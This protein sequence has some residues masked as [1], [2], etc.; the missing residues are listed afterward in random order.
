MVLVVKRRGKQEP[1]DDKKLYASVYSACKDVNM[2]VHKCEG[3]AAKIVADV[4]THFKGKNTVN[5]TEIFGA[6]IGLLAKHH[7]AAA[8]M[9]E[10]HRE[11][12]G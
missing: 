9:Y 7:E 8:F 4:K 11:L 6:V 5:S 1:F 12:S 3:T 10:T 2:D